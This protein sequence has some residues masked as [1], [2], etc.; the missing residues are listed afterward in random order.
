MRSAVILAL[1]STSIA[2][3]FGNGANSLFDGKEERQA[4]PQG[5][6]PG[7]PG[8]GGQGGGMGFPKPSGTGPMPPL[9][10]GGMPGGFPLP[11][12]NEENG[13]KE[14]VSVCVYVNKKKSNI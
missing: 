6:M 9:S 3:P 7:L 11:S 13:A 12:S 4:P 14:R 2:L 10:T 1:A 8:G 5:G